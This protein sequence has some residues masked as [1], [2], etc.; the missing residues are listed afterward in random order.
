LV[1]AL[2]L[3]LELGPCSL[4]LGQQAPAKRKKKKIK[5]NFTKKKKSR[6]QNPTRDRN[7]RLRVQVRGRSAPEA[8]FSAPSPGYLDLF[9]FLPK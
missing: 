4:C 7:S 6:S 3:A 2:V 5:K 1:L 9:L 8:G